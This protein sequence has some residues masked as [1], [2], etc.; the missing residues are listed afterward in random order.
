MSTG[1]ERAAQRAAWRKALAAATY[2][3]SHSAWKMAHL[4]TR[5]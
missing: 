1:A 3:L 4:T 5:A 2:H